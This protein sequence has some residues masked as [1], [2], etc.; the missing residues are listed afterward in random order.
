[1]TV[2]YLIQTYHL[3]HQALRLATTLR[4]GS[5]DALIIVNHDESS[6]PPDPRLGDVVDAV[7]FG[8]GGRG[9]YATVERLF[10]SL[11]WIRARALR[12]DWVLNI[13]G[14]DYP[15][16]H[17]AQIEAQLGAGTADAF[18]EFFPVFDPFCRWGRHEG[19]DRYRF[20]YRWIRPNLG[21]RTRRALRPLALV[22][23]VQ[24]FVRVSTSYGLAVGTRRASAPF[25][26][27]RACHGGAFYGA[28]NRRAVDALLDALDADPEI[29]RHYRHCLV[30]EESILQSVL[31]NSPEV[32][33]RNW[34]GRYYDFR[35]SVAGRPKVL[36][37]DD[38][39]RMLQSGAWFA[40]KFDESVDAEVLDRL[41]KHLGLGMPIRSSEL[42]RAA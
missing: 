32:S 13:T 19:A 21:E 40:R 16:A 20:D 30:P 18:L 4:R 39:P 24:P 33:V 37:T 11:A 5:P 31:V 7:L 27:D 2:A 26:R 28:M 34:S 17:P 23:R 29:E 38:L 22:N 6:A 14:Q 35:G 12:P 41:D 42:V 36:G 3:P 1:M 25:G 15:I 8:P 10:D 9:D